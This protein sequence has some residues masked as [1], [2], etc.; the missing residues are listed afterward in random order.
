MANLFTGAYD[1]YLQDVNDPARNRSI[2]DALDTYLQGVTAAQNAVLD[3]MAFVVVAADDTSHPWGG[4]RH[5]EQQFSASLLK[6]AATYC[7]Y[8]LRRYARDFIDSDS[9]PTSDDLYAGLD[10]DAQPAIDLLA[11][12]S[13]TSN[14]YP[15]FR[16]MLNVGVDSA[17]TPVSVDFAPQYRA[18]LR[19]MTVMS[20][21]QA[22]MQCIHGLGFG[23]LN[24]KLADDGFFTGDHG[25]WLAGDYQ[26]VWPPVRIDSVND[27]PSAQCTTAYQFARLMTI[28]F[29]QRLVTE[30]DSI[31]MRGLLGQNRGW[32]H[33]TS[34]P[35]WPHGGVDV[36]ASKVGVGSLK[37][38]RQVMS[39][40]LYAVDVNGANFVV[41]WQNLQRPTNRADLALVADVIETAISGYTP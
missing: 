5:D 22:S 35:V 9:P 8:E 31:E 12:S 30:D 34:P 4:Q 32:M 3:K 6:L 11:P 7:A 13:I 36:T 38:N 26:G 27:G 25:V 16:T 29:D 23:Y 15:D 37:D 33:F 41:V 14:L 1:T 19:A 10:G 39:E 2:Q 18:N 17:G 20:D 40:G 21:D 24:A 28:L